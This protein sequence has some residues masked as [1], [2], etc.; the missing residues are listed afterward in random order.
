MAKRFQRRCLKLFTPTTTTTDAEH[1]YTISSPCD[2]NSLGD[3]IITENSKEVLLLS[4]LLDIRVS[5]GAVSPIVCADLRL[6]GDHLLGKSC[7]LALLYILY[8]NCLFL[9]SVIHFD[10]QGRILVLIVPVP[11]H[12][13]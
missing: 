10:F 9:I 3:L 6:L 2:P 12:C 11:R 13:L 8:V 7:S 4:L 1:G 5:F